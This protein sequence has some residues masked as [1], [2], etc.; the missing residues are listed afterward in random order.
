MNHRVVVTG[1]GVISP[2][3]QNVTDFWQNLLSATNGI[4]PITKFDTTDFQTRIAG[5]V[6]NFDILQYIEKKE[7]RRMALFTQYAIAASFNAL[8]SADLFPLVEQEQ[9][10]VNIGCGIGGLSVIEEQHQRLLEKGPRRVSPLLIPMFIP[11]MASGQVAI[12]TGA[13]GPNSCT[14]TACAS[15]NHAIGDA[16]RTIQRGAANVM[17]TGGTES[18]ITPLSI[19]GF[20]SA[21]AL[22]TRNETPESAS[23]PFDKD[24]DGFV[25]GEGAGILILESL[26]HALKRGVPILAEV[27]G[28]AMTADAYHI[29]APTPEGDGIATA[30]KQAVA[31]AGLSLKD[32][33][34]INAHGTSTPINDRTE[35]KAIKHVFGDYASELLISSTKSMTGHLLGAAGGIEA[36][37]TILSVKNNIVHPTRNLNE[38][39]PECDLNYIPHQAREADIDYALSNS[40]GFGGHNTALV[41]GKYQN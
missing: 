35:T 14:V 19:A 29:T 8:K 36:I 41:F 33:Q 11:N 4:G 15:A 7:A 16:F 9:C 39:D 28:Y 3:G 21:K 37:A 26:E 27:R 6:Q 10:G 38:P 18:V 31:D 32:I 17:I 12:H 13:K 22:S 24:R 40:M 25:M 2:I 5:E 34:Y 20:C 30:M 23:R 1:L